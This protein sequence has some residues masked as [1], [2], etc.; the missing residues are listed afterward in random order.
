MKSVRKKIS[1]QKDK[2]EKPSDFSQRAEVNWDRYS[3][4]FS[5]HFSV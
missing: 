3:A 5:S 2:Q 4:E 1:Q